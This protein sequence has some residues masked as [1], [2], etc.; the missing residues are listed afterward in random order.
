MIPSNITTL[1]FNNVRE[2]IKSYLRTRRE[3]TD[4][5][6]TGSSLSYMLDLLAYNTY[7]S[8]F[9]ANMAL[10]EIFLPSSTIRDNVINTAKLLNYTPRS[11]R[12]SKACLKFSVQTELSSAG[13]YP[14]GVT[15]SAGNLVSGIID[16]EAYS[17]VLP[18]DIS[19]EVNPVTGI[20]TFDNFVVYEGDLLD[21][22]FIVDRTT[23]NQKFV[24]PNQ[25]ID[26]ST[27]QVF[28]RQN[29]QATQRDSYNFAE[30]TTNLDSSSRSYFIS[31]TDDMRYEIIF[32]DGVFGRQLLD[33]EIVEIKYISTN[34]KKANDIND[35]RLIGEANDS[36][37]RRI[38]N[39]RIT[40]A[41]VE[42]SQL[43]SD[44]E[45]I[46]SI[47]YN[48]PKYYTSQYR[49]VTATDY[50]NI[51]R[52]IYNN[53]DS[54]VAFG[55]EEF[56]PKIYGK[57]FVVVKTKT[58]TQL[59][60]STKK[61]IVKDL[62]EYSMASIEPV[63][64]DPDYLYV[65]LKVL[66]L[67]DQNKTNKSSTD[68][69]NQVNQAIYD[70]GQQEQLNQFNKTFNMTKLQRAIDDSD[71][72][73]KTNLTQLTFYKNISPLPGVVNTYCTSF[74][75]PLYKPATDPQQP[76]NGTG[77]GTTGDGTGT[78]GTGTAGTGTGGTGTGG[79]LCEQIPVVRSSGFRT[80]DQPGLTQYFEDDGNGNLRTYYVSD[81]KKVYTNRSAGTVDYNSGNVCFGPINITDTDAIGGNTAD[82]KISVLSI[83]QTSGIIKAPNPATIVTLSV[84]SVE[85]LPFTLDPFP[86][87][88]GTLG[89]TNLTPVSINFDDLAEIKFTP[90]YQID[91]S[92]SG[93]F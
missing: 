78:A 69:K 68:I 44:P 59:N 10:N 50:E 92:N 66:A 1:D 65:R 46:E 8:A 3:F 53:V 15:I 72:S 88:F 39:N 31:E 20:A 18:N 74:G 34:G 81:A 27:I 9:N 28:V 43:G 84:P 17:F 82:S 89:I 80:I 90:L 52:K 32:G 2:S 40:F 12:C 30:T 71:E 47:K 11:I 49:A 48:A 55:G 54:V 79:G 5:D 19:A 67:F 29:A 70:F 38:F 87:N 4:Y 56:T 21:F 75:V 36:E 6:F 41:V 51:T 13:I 77:T 23:P 62:K 37:G 25:N 26:T 16:A 85:V 42:K 22:S 63:V 57:V 61:S 14:F 7:Y 33:G 24:L 93:C 60:A 83:P 91:I 76:A 64:L 45:S 35:F 73:M 86:G 58:G